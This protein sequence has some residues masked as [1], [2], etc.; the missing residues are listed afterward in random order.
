MKTKGVLRMLLVVSGLAV[1]LF[2]PTASVGE[3]YDHFVFLPIVL[4]NY[5][6]Y[7]GPCYLYWELSND[8]N[9]YGSCLIGWT[10]YTHPAACPDVSGFQL[11]GI[12][13][14]PPWLYYYNHPMYEGDCCPDLSSILCCISQCYLPP[15]SFQYCETDLD[16]S[17]YYAFGMLVHIPGY[18]SQW[19]GYSDWETPSASGWWCS[20]DCE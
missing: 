6:Q 4:R 5:S 14:P 9:F 3:E 11:A 1:V 18:V 17:N 15:D 16:A 2:L 8:C 7:E 13:S 12:Y 10:A 19:I 20:A